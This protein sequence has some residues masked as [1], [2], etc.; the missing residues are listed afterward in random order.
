MHKPFR[1]AFKLAVCL[2]VL[3]S[4]SCGAAFAEKYYDAGL[5]FFKDKKYSEATRYFEQSIKEAPWDSNAFY[6]SALSYHYMGDFKKAAERYGDCIERFPGTPA[7]SQATAALKAVDPQFFQRKKT[8]QEKTTT[9]SSPKTTSSEDANPADKGTIEGQDQT[10]LFFRMS[11]KDKVV[12]VRVNGRTTRAIFDPAGEGTSFSR[13]Q[14]NAIGVRLDKNATEFK[15]EIALGGIVRKNFP[16]VVEDTGLPARI[17]SSFLDAFSVDVNEAGKTIDLKRRS[18]KTTTTTAAAAGVGFTRE[19]KSLVVGAE[20]NGHGTQMIFDPDGSGITLTTQQ[21]KSVGI[22]FEDAEVEH[23]NPAELP[24][25]G[26]AGFVSP[27]ERGPA[28]KLVSFRMKFGPIERLEVSGKV[29]EQGPKKPTF[30]P[31]F[32][33]GAGYKFDIDYKANRIYLTRK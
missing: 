27:E 1:D 30:G 15:G 26:E 14:L 16:I 32:I 2:S 8:T 33:S 12:D 28:A 7:C 23:K 20:I 5:K 19:G 6:Y 11:D 29:A 9:G 4:L 31:D 21:A 17:G 24:Q 18:A 10:R 22:R 3:L 13:D 25:R